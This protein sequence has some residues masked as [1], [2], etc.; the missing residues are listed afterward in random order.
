MADV[1]LRAEKSKP[2]RSRWIWP[3]LLATTVFLASGESEVAA[4]D[5]VNVDKVG[6]ALVFGLLGTLAA[7]AMAPERWWLGAVLAS[8]YG[9]GDEFRQSFTPGR[10]VDAWDWLADTVGAALSVGLYVRWTWYRRTLE[11]K[12]WP[13]R[14]RRVDL[15]PAPAPDNGAP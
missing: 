4:P 6:H 2:V 9:L 14:Q 1:E 13:I 11:M 8:A 5:I 7:R 10:S 15:C 3:V 12:I